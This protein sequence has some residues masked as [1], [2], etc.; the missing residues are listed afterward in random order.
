MSLLAPEVV[1]E[2]VL[3][4]EFTNIQTNAATLIP[5]IFT[6]FPQAYQNEA[7]DYMTNI[8]KLNTVFNY[9]FDPALLPSF[10]IILSAEGEA[11]EYLDDGVEYADQNPNTL[12]AEEFG[13]DW[14]AT[15][16]VIIRA[17]KS[18][19]CIILYNLCKWVLLKNRQFLEENFIKAS[20]FSGSDLMYETE[21]KPTFVFARTIKI[22]CRVLN[23]VNVD[24]T[25]DPTIQQV[26]S[27][28]G[29]EVRALPQENDDITS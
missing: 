21:R 28:F 4:T 24:I 1:I 16:T 23:T 8:F 25:G 11:Q 6:Q 5:E 9:Y 14:Q 2:Q 20:T 29:S 3:N 19:Q 7:I 10:N 17:E 22:S 13:S 26:I 27:G 12:T 15:I 18:R